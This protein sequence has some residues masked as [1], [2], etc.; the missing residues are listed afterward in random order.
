ME[1]WTESGKKFE[2]NLTNT[3]EYKVKE[4][5]TGRIFLKPFLH[6]L[7]YRVT[8]GSVSHSFTLYPKLI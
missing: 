6:L 7:L 2:D 5:N 8:M 3:L 4:W 1:P